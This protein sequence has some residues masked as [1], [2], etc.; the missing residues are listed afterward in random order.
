MFHAKINL[1][2]CRVIVELAGP[3]VR[4]LTTVTLPPNSIRGLA[5]YVIEQ[6]VS[7]GGSIG[8]YV[9]SNNLGP[10]MLTIVKIWY[11]W[12]LLYDRPSSCSNYQSS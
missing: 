11:L 7:N 6:C 2:N 4:F 9:S 5:Y 10:T 8:G 3:G 1:G 12:L